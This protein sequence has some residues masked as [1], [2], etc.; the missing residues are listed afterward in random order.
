MQAIAVAAAKHQT[1]GKFINDDDFTVFYHVIPILLEKGFCPN[2]IGNEV[3]PLIIFISIEIFDS[4]LGFN[5]GDTAFVQCGAFGFFFDHIIVAFHQTGNDLS[6]GVVILRGLFGLTGNDQRC[7][8]FIDEDTIHFVDDGIVEIPLYHSAFSYRHIIS[9]IVKTEFIIG[10]VGN[11]R[12][13]SCFLFIVIETVNIKA[14]G[15]TEKTEYLPHPL[16][17][18]GGQIIVY[19]DDVYP[20]AGNG[21]EISRKCCYQGFTF[22][23]FHLRYTAVVKHHAADELHI[24]VAH[25]QRALCSFANYGKCLCQ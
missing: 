16:T 17:V 13:I 21:I 10:A 19:G 5:L 14:Y 3:A 22:P 8:S 1:A 6:S 11:I 18:A 9:Q 12:S 25:L 20:P 7:S 4:Q 15:E 24:K 23:G 2:G